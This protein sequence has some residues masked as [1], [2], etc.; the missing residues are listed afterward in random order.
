M[1]ASSE[2][3]VTPAFAFFSETSFKWISSQLPRMHSGVALPS[4]SYIIVTGIDPEWKNATIFVMLQVITLT[5]SVTI[6]NRA[7]LS[8]RDIH[9]EINSLV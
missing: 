2:R 7:D 3:K 5:G 1:G 8:G 9:K 4:I 6:K